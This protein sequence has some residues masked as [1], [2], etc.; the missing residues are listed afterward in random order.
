VVV[1]V[2]EEESVKEPEFDAVSPDE[3]GAQ[4]SEGEELRGLR[5]STDCRLHAVVDLD[6]KV[7]ELRGLRL[8][9]GQLVEEVVQQEEVIEE[10]AERQRGRLFWRG[11]TRHTIFY[12]SINIVITPNNVQTHSP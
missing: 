2:H 4:A 9:L 1:P 10:M 3:V 7:E 6:L 11:V 5:A 12:K 8:G